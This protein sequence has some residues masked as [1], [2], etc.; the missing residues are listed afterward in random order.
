[1]IALLDN[2]QDLDECER[3]IGLP[4]GQLLTPLTRY[5]L[6]D[7]SRPWAIDNG[8]FKELDVPGL[9]SL[10]KREEHHRDNCLFVAVPDIVGNAQRTLELFAH[11]APQMAGWRLALVCQDGQESLPIPWAQIAAVF[12]GGSTSWKCG[13]HVEAIIRTAKVLGKHVHVGRVNHPDRWAHFERLGA[14]SADGTGLA[15]YSHMRH[16]IAGRGQIATLFDEEAA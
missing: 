14:D 1:M 13:P 12:I 15:R 4:V 7:P 11:F 16:A 9:F 5:R 2:G 8:G 10:L 6:R 3:E